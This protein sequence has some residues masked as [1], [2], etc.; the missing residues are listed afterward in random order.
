MDV[1]RCLDAVTGQ[2]RWAVHHLTQGNLDY[3]NSPRATPLILDGL[4]FLLGA[5]GQLHC[6]ELATGKIVWRKDL[7]AE[8]DAHEKLPWGFCASPLAVDG[9]IIVNPGGPKA[10]LV[11]LETRSGE[12]VWK[13]AGSPPGYGSLIAAKFGGRTQIVGHDANSLGG[14]DPIT[15]E[16]LWKVTPPKKG[17]FNVPTPIAYRGRLIVSTEKNGTRLF[18]FGH[19]GQINPQP[20]AFNK[21][22]TPDTQSSIVVG[23]RLLGASGRLFCLDLNDGLKSIWVAE[24][25]TFDNHVSLIGSG[26]AALASGMNGELRLID[27][28]ASNY[29]LLGKLTALEDETGIYAHPAVVGDRLYLRGTDAVYCISLSS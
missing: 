29:K 10:S 18:E 22:L 3:G 8:F 28:L 15:G 25:P 1:F 4:I 21:D 24:E 13:T 9:K 5:F 20:I 17:D 23:S 11:A 16:R 6:V 19:D 26:R 7:P 27:A 14:W 2:Q 12:V